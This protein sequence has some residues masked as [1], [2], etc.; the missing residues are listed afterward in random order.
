MAQHSHHL[1]RAEMTLV[2][3]SVRHERRNRRELPSLAFAP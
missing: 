3:P 2:N 1:R